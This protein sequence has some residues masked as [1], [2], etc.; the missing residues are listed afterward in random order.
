MSKVQKR[1]FGGDEG[2]R[3]L[4]LY[5]YKVWTISSSQWDVGR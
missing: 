4:S 3:K 1:P 5:F 2:F